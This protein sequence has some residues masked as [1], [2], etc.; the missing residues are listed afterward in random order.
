MNF[1]EHAAKPLLEAAGIAIPRGR[2]ARSADD[3]RAVA[4]SLGGPVVVK[5]QVPAGK[6]G[7]AGGV[8]PADDPAAAGEAANAILGMEIAGHRVESVLVEERAPIAAEYYAAVLND[9]ASKGPL[10]MFSP[11]GGMDVEEVAAATPER[12]RSAP[13]DIRHGLDPESA[14][15]MLD[16]LVPEIDEAPVAETLAALYRAYRDNDA[17]LLEVNPLARRRDGRLVALDCKFT[18]DDSAVKR[19]EAIAGAGSPEP[20]TDLEARAQGLGLKYIELDGDV[21]VI[22]NGAGLTMTT[23]DVIARHGGRPANFLEIGGEAYTK[24]KPALELVLANPRVKCLVVNFCGAFA[25]TDVM[26]G[27]VLDAWEALAPPAP[28][29]FSVHGTGSTEAREMLR[30]RLGVTPY[31]TMDEAIAAAVAASSS[32]PET[33]AGPDVR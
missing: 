18:L 17:E 21:G 19:R 30:R 31:P 13:V 24:A 23:M 7:K 3:A 14:R 4:T 20:M 16:G 10:V 22:A 1:E 5:A 2:L 15:A 27:G 8:R 32:G 9:P 12:V 33:P 25:R 28:V 29:F 6:R 11:E 26:T